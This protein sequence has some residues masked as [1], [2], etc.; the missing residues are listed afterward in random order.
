MDEEPVNPDVIRDRAHRLWAP[1][2]ACAAV[3]TFEG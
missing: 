1:L 2:A 3:V